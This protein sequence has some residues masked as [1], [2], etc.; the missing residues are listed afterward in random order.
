MYSESIPEDLNTELED[1]IADEWRYFCMSKPIPPRT[2][3][4]SKPPVDDPLNMLSDNNSKIND[5][6]NY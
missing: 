2:R 3:K 1:H 5:W 6:R 4:V